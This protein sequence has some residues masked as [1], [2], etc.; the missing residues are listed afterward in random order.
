MVYLEKCNIKEVT[1][2]EDFLSICDK[3]KYVPDCKMK[4]SVFYGYMVAGIY[5]KKTKVFVSY[6]DNKMS[7][8]AVITIS[9]NLSGELTLFVVFLWV[10]PHYRKLWKDYMKYI[11][12]KARE[13]NAVKISFTTSRSEKAIERQMGKYGYKKIYNVIEKNIK[14]VI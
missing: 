11:E 13:L 7:G 5:N 14:E 10:N 4:E 1:E 12:K 2:S 6:D 9:N 3:L 8:C